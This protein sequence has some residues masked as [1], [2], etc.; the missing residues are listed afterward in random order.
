MARSIIAIGSAALLALG[1]AVTSAGPASAA[2]CTSAGWSTVSGGY[3][4]SLYCSGAGFINGFGSTRNDAAAEAQALA[5][6]Y[7]ETGVDCSGASVGQAPK[8]RSA[9]LYC[10][11]A[12]YIQSY[13]TTLTDAAREARALATLYAT[14]DRLCDGRSAESTIRGLQVRLYC[15]DEGFVEGIGSTLTAAAQQARL[16]AS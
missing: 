1:A 8:G 3:R 12:G 13:G 14:S 2:S 10:S 5:D 7:T 6:L 4:V 15:S 16:A 11:E 9:E